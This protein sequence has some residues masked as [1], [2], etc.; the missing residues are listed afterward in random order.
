VNLNEVYN[1]L[2]HM[3][4]FKDTSWEAIKVERLNSFTNLSYK[5]SAHN[6]VYI[7]RVA[8]KGTSAYI[9]RTAEEYNARI[10]TAAGLNAQIIFFDT[11]EG[12]MLCRFLEGPH[13]DKVRFNSDPTAPARAALTLKQIHSLNQ[14]FKSRFGPF[15]PIDYYLNILRKR[16]VPLP[17]IYGEVK[18]GADAVRQTLEAAS[19]PTTP[20]HNDTCPENFLEVGRRLYLIDWEYS[21]MNDPM[22]DLGN[23]SVEAGFGHEEDQT[24]ME[25]YCGGFVPPRLYDRVVLYKVMSDYF[26]GLWSIVQYANDN[27]AT[28]FWTYALNRFEHCKM[29]M[30]SAEFDHCLNAVRTSY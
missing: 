25:A 11:K 18:Q 21:G 28:D 22:W 9:D 17:D 10:A 20:C 29:L 5:V 27:P 1:V 16:Q 7:L 19:I 12:T 24:M 8:G 2:A 3:P 4:S 26:W 14:A 6:K 23:L 15:A 13:M 30:R